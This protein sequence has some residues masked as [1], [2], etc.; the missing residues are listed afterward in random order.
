MIETINTL[1]ESAS[2]PQNSN[3]YSCLELQRAFVTLTKEQ[4][5]CKTQTPASL[6]QQKA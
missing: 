6:Y 1:Q 5:Q 2:H 4:K 3:A